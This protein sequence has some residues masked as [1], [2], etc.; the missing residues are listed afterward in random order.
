M[1]IGINTT[2]H[3]AIV[4]AIAQ[5]LA[6]EAR[7]EA[8]V[9]RGVAYERP[10]K[11]GAKLGAYLELGVGNGQVINSIADIVEQIWAVDFAD[12]FDSIKKHRNVRCCRMTTRAFFEQLRASSD[13][14]LF[15]LAFVDACHSHEESYQD[16][17]DLRQ[18]IRPNGIILMHDTHPPT[19]EFLAGWL[20]ND[21]WKTAWKIREN[22]S[23]RRHWEICTLPVAFGITILRHA[24]QQVYFKD[25]GSTEEPC[26]A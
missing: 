22:E 6:D 3:V 2:R 13:T 17:L 20:C 14:P 18:F 21:T 25:S 7:L 4:K 23:L 26:R 24:D 1:R 15:D 9:K 19:R 10:T 11:E 12:K 8:Y 16:F 5:A